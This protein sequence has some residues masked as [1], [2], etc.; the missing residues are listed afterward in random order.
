MTGIEPV[1]RKFWRLSVVP[2]NRTGKFMSCQEVESCRK[3]YQS[4]QVNRT[5][6]GLVY[7]LYSLFLVCQDQFLTNYNIAV[8]LS[9][10]HTKLLYYGLYY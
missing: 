9:C 6:A 1:K 8:C 7:I 10:R 5:I 2:T 3:P 4:F